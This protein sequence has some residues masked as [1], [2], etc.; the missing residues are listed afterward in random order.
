MSY[1]HAQLYIDFLEDFFL[2][3]PTI[4]SSS[5]LTDFLANIPVLPEGNNCAHCITI[6]KGPQPKGEYS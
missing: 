1:I 5:M 3:M 6:T 4:L 2:T